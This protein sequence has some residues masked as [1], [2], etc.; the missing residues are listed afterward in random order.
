MALATNLTLLT[1]RQREEMGPRLLGDNVPA[2]FDGTH[3]TMLYVGASIKHCQFAHHFQSLGYTLTL[4]EPFKINAL[5]YL[6]AADSPFGTIILGE[7]QKLED[8]KFDEQWDVVFWWQ[9]PQHVTKE[10]LPGII[11]ML[12]RHS[13][14]IVLGCPYGRYEQGEVGG[15]KYEAHLANLYPEDFKGLMDGTAIAGKR[16]GRDDSLLIAWK[17]TGE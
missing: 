4:I 9:G 16:G 5:K 12:S 15:N 1:N 8:N 17:E 10:E 14:L 3:K 13:K 6:H 11:T 7:V 2:L